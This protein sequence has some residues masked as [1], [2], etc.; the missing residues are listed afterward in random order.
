MGDIEFKIS[1]LGITL[2]MKQKSW[3]F[4][5]KGQLNTTG[6]KLNVTE[7]LAYAYSTVVPIYPLSVIH[8]L[9]ITHLNPSYFATVWEGQGRGYHPYFT[10]GD[11]FLKPLAPRIVPI[12]NKNLIGNEQHIFMLWKTS[13]C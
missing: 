1:G 12:F 4:E 7:T 10:V 6:L 11:V 5:T 8:K 9:S 13:R 2:N 3:K